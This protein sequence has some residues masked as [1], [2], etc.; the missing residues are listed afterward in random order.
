MIILPKTK[1]T[2]QKVCGWWS[3]RLLQLVVIAHLTHT[4]AHICHLKSRTQSCVVQKT[5]RA[6]TVRTCLQ[7]VQQW[8]LDG[9]P[10]CLVSFLMCLRLIAFICVMFCRYN[11]YALLQ[12][13]CTILRY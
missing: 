4:Y 3:R 5:V 11:F 7:A 9:D 12:M 1:T 6:Q 13:K 10:Q 8:A 2:L